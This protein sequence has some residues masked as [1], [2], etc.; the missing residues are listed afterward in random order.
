MK[1]I[2]LTIII[3]VMF[4]IAGFYLAGP[5]SSSSEPVEAMKRWANSSVVVKSAT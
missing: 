3:V 5:F 4:A 2:A 1:K